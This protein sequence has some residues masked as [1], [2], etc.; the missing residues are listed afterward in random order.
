M[1]HARPR[2]TDRIDF[3][4]G[5][6]ADGV[7]GYLAGDDDQRDRIHVRRRDARDR[8]R[9]AR[10]GGNEGDADAPRCT[11]IAVGRVHR[12]LLVPHQHVLDLVLLEELVVDVENGAARIAENVVHVFRLQAS[13]HDLCAADF[14]RTFRKKPNMKHY[15]QGVRRSSR[16]LAASR[17]GPTYSGATR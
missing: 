13:H 5:I 17:R 16:R 11:R 1:L 6:L 4:E 15:R 12:T 7:R 9:H 3:L 8:V 2:D 14:H 10:S